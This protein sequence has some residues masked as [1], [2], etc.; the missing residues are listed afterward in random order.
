M[1]GAIEHGKHVFVEKPLCLYEEE[2][3][4]IAALLRERPDL[5]LSSNLPLRLSPRFR[6]CAT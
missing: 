5:R 3:R 6:R 4:E 1:R 2:G